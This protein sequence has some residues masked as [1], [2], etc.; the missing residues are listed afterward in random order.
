MCGNF[1]TTVKDAKKHQWHHIQGEVKGAVHR[2]CLRI[3]TSNLTAC[4]ITKVY[5]NNEVMRNQSFTELVEA[6]G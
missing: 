4:F 6:C 1:S 3:H 2:Y 5:K